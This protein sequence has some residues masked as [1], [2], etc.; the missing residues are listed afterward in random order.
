MDTAGCAIRVSTQ[1]RI[2]GSKVAGGVMRWLSRQG[3]D[4]TQAGAANIKN[5]CGSTGLKM[6]RKD[7][8]RLKRF[9]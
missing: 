4:D 1:A 6:I 7:I 2:L 5:L 8:S 3:E 9:G